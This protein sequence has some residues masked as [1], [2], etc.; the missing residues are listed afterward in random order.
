MSSQ[1]FTSYHTPAF[2]SK[3]IQVVSDSTINSLIFD[4]EGEKDGKVGQAIVVETLSSTLKM[5]Y[6][7]EFINVYKLEMLAS[8]VCRIAE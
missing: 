2:K 8:G 7:I 6:T 3:M 4:I 1:S 5:R